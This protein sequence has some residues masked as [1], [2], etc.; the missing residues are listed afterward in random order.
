MTIENLIKRSSIMLKIDDVLND[1][2]LFGEGR[3]PTEVMIAN[4]P[5]LR[6]MFELA[7]QVIFEVNSYIQKERTTEAWVVGDNKMRITTFINGATAKIL[8]VRDEQGRYVDFWINNEFLILEKEGRYTIRYSCEPNVPNMFVDI[9]L[10]K[11]PV[12]EDLIVNGLNAYYCLSNGMINEFNI[13]HSH[14][15]DGLNR[16][17]KGKVFSMPCR[18]WNG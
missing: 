4:N 12:S 6:L 10:C 1:D 11:G 5:T 8:S 13:Y 17:R 2:N 14:Y 16:L 3:E 18:R 9:D 7:K 15:V